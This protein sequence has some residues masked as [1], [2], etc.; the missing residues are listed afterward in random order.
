MCFYEVSLESVSAILLLV[1][2]LICLLVFFPLF[3]A[4][5]HWTL[6]HLFDIAFVPLSMFLSGLAGMLWWVGEYI[7]VIK[8]SVCL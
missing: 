5:H 4:V 2:L 6:V 8:I 3:L 1:P 7:Q